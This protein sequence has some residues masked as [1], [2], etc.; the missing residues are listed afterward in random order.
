[1]KSTRFATLCVALGLASFLN[2]KSFA[3][4]YTDGSGETINSAGGTIDFI[5][6]EVTHDATDVTFKLT[7]NGNISTT[8]WG[9]FLIGI[10][11]GKGGASGGTKTGNGWGRPINLDA[12]ANGGMTHWI[13]SWV[14]GGG[15]SQ[16]WQYSGTSWSQ[17]GSAN[18]TF[19]PGAT[20]VLQ[21]KV[22]RATLGVTTG[23][24]IYFDAYSSGG[25]GGDSAIDALAKSSQSVANWGDTYTSAAP[26]LY[27]YT[28][29]APS[30]FDG[31]T[32]PDVTDTDDDN[33]GLPDAVETGT[34][35]WVSSSDTGTNPKNRDTDGDGLFDGVETNT[36]TYTDVTNTGS[37]PL[38]S[39]DF[40]SDMLPDFHDPDDDNDN[41]ADTVE[42]NTSVWTSASDTGTN[43]KD[44]DSDN[45]G[46][47]DGVETNTGTYASATNTGT[48]PLAADQARVFLV[49]NDVLFPGGS[50]QVD[51]TNNLL[52]PAVGGPYNIKSITRFIA[53]PTNNIEFKFTGGNW[54]LNWGIGSNGVTVLNTNTGAI[55][56]TLF[57]D[58]TPT[59]DD[60]TINVN[61]GRARGEYVFA[62]NDAANSLEFSVTRKSYSTL[63][64]YVAAY[65]LT[66]AN[67][68]GTADPDGDT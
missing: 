67:A 61:I 2:S 26:N 45:D 65:G 54:D 49:G 4:T 55:T 29:T 33:D 5:G 34:G 43:P 44:D 53:S 58:K 35:I 64:D 25:G 24:T 1:M 51:N 10:A 19:T 66:G 30:D 7:V 62:F 56:G 68:T 22:S 16:L 40:D 42:T 27:S 14:D 52:S 8:D 46:L 48:S 23:D 41:L 9:K 50:W 13:G 28:L 17:S 32:I 63:T 60:R 36:G 57:K 12:G 3:D 37:N 31:D 21:F 38:V 39:D 47:K 15:G 6:A 20:S 11:N 18:H 59:A